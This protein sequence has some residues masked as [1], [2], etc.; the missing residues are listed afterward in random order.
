VPLSPLTAW[1]A[2]FD[3]GHIR[4]GQKLLVT[5]AAG[6]TGV[7]AV[8]FG[9]MI[10]ANRPWTGSLQP[11]PEAAYRPESQPIRQL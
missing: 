3:H 9:R 6:G 10:G 2:L 5:G 4:M 7:W 8:R 11:L 1:Q